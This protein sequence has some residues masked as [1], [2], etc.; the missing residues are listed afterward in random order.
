M[1]RNRF[2]ATRLTPA[3]A[4]Q[5]WQRSD[6]ASAFTRPDYL[7]QLVDEVEWWGVERSGE[8][9]AAWPLVRAVAGG[10]IAPPPFCYYVGPMFDRGLRQATPIRY[11]SAYR[12]IFSALVDAITQSH[13]YFAFSLPLGITDLRVLEWWNYDHPDRPGFSIKSRHTARI[14]LSDFCDESSLRRSFASTRQRDIDRWNAIRPS[15]VDDVP[16]DQLIEMHDQALSR[17]ESPT[18]P[19]RH[20]AFR[21]MIS[22][23]NSGAGEI[24]GVIPPGDDKVGAVS[25]L[26]DGPTASNSIFYA[27]SD[28]WREAGLTAWANWLSLMRARSLGKR[29]FDFNGANSPGRAADKH[30]YGAAPELYFNGSFGSDRGRNWRPQ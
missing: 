4:H 1:N 5:L 6:E 9:I 25:I 18:S 20:I 2:A 3:Q 27:A 13:P 30:F 24:I 11:W 23:V 15:V 19:A 16:T 22:L 28:G 14:D 10:D 12:D 26:L 17:S 7:A 8:V 21:R 29:W